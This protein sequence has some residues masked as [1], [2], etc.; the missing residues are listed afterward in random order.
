M[1]SGFGWNDGVT[2]GVLLCLEL[3]VGVKELLK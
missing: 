1:V 2:A 3:V